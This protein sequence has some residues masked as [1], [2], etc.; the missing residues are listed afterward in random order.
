[1]AQRRQTSTG[2][3]WGLALTTWR[4]YCT[5]H[6]DPLIISTFLA[7]FII[8]QIYIS[9]YV[10][11][12]QDPQCGLPG[13]GTE[14][15]PCMMQYMYRATY[16]PGSGWE[17]GLEP[18]GPLQL[19]PSAQVLNYGQS[20]FEGM[21][22]QR[23]AKGNIVVFRPD[24]NAARMMAGKNVSLHAV[25]LSS[26]QTDAAACLTTSTL[27]VPTTSSGIKTCLLKAALESLV[28]N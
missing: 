26:S 8:V 28:I 9:L 24:E 16:H 14:G 4:R 2:T 17:G 27:N 10:A 6:F 18:Y 1:M 25:Q 23:S 15:S 5:H 20:V 21:K 13:H 7:L 3:N 12:W 19:D 11:Q 22:A